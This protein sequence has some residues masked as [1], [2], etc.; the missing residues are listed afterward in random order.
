LESFINYPLASLINCKE[1]GA[2]DDPTQRMGFF[3]TPV[4][5]K[6][7]GC[8]HNTLN[9]EVPMDSKVFGNIIVL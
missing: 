9:P 8:S 6:D 1:L 4:S 3:L 5:V 7:N 2:S